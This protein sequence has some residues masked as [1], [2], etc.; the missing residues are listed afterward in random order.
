VAPGPALARRL[1]PLKIDSDRRIWILALGKA[2]VPMAETAV[3][4]LHERGVEPAGGVVVAPAAGQS[5]HPRLTHV[6]GDHPEPGPGSLAAAQ[7]L[8]ET[9]SR[10]RAGD[11]VWVLLSGGTTSLVGAPELGLRSDELTAIYSLLLGSGL[12]ITAMNRIRKRFS[13]WGGGKLARALAPARVRVY[14]VSDVIGDDL[15]SIGS[16]PCVPDPTTAAEVRALLEDAGLWH[17][18]PDSARTLVS[19]I[20]TGKSAETPKAGD[21]AFAQVT[22]ELIASNG[23]A[24]DAAAKRAAELGLAFS[25]RKTPIAGEASDV[26]ASIATDLLKDCA[27]FLQSQSKSKVMIWGGETTV[28]LSQ[29]STGLGG[30]CQELALAGAR[31]LKNASREVALLAAG[32]DGRDGPTDAAGA[33]V[34]G[35]TWD[36][37]TAAGRDPAHDLATHDAYHA[38]DAAGALLRPGLTGTNVMDIVVGICGTTRKA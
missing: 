29:G 16:G 27:R 10:V 23:L 1:Q 3:H 37:I 26:G 11:E 9:V 2:A 24:L 22:T 7:A 30:R 5:P 35:G 25:V 15:P 14:A 34:D 20:E 19:A 6:Q 18:I 31:I 28:S 32:T 8:G 4:V 36:A 12:D 33:I 21:P 13:R 38:L 17:R